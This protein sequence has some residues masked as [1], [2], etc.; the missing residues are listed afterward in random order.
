DNDIDRDPNLRKCGKNDQLYIINE[1]FTINGGL[2]CSDDGS[3]HEIGDKNK[4]PIV[5]ESVELV[6]IW[7]R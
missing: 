1:N 2:R 7:K 6:C 4:V 5:K 3:W